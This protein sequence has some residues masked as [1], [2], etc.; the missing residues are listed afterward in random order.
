MSFNFLD[1]HIVDYC[2][3]DCRHCYLRKGSSVMPLDMIRDISTD[4]L[5]TDFP[6]SQSYIVLA[7]GDPL[8]HPEFPEV[9]RIIRELGCSISLSTNGIL[10]PQYVS[11]FQTGDSIQVS[12]DG[13]EAAHDFIRGDGSYEKAVQALYVLKENNVPHSI[14]FTI[15]KQNHH[16]LDHM[17]DLCRDSGSY[18]FNF[19][20]YQPIRNHNLDPISFSQWIELRKYAKKRL[21]SHRTIMPGI[22]VEEGCIAGILGL[23]VLPDGTYWDCSRNQEII[24]RYPQKIRN[25]L[26]WDHIRNHTSRDQF[27]TCCKRM[28]YG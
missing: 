25:V 7:G 18:L 11:I 6:L 17:I 4:F 15:N 14:S 22:C 24:G 20:P 5:Q 2:Q 10:V 21:E 1:L 27:Q 12:V 8:L 19:N 9:C 13:D 28:V 23:T 16:C 26:F 3:L